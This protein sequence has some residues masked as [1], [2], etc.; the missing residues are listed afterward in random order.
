M[1][2]FGVYQ[3][4][5]QNYHAEEECKVFRGWFE[6]VPVILPHCQKPLNGRIK[7]QSYVKST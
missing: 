6:L 7:L 2:N 5:R 1:G 4:A 3:N